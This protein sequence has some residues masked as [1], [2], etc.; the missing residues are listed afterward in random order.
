MANNLTDRVQVTKVV[1]IG[2]LT[3]LVDVDAQGGMLDVRVP[4]NKM[5]EQFSVFAS[6][7]LVPGVFG[8]WKALTD[9]MNSQH[10]FGS[11]ATMEDVEGVWFELILDDNSRN[12]TS[13]L[14]PS[15][16]FFADFETQD[17]KISDNLALWRANLR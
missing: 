4:V 12:P 9:N 1:A 16:D 11:Q 8:T 2:D 15:S 3:Q 6:E 17:E 14:K 7:A 13:Y 5:V 10:K